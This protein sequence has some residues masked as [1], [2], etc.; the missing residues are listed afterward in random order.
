SAAVDLLNRSLLADF[1][2]LQAA[3]G[4]GLALLGSVGPLR[5]ALMRQGVGPSP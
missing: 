1:L 4:L 2:P 5:R 3:R